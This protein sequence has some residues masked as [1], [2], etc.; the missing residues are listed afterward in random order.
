M[1]YRLEIILLFIFSE[2]VVSL[3]LCPYFGFAWRIRAGGEIVFLCVSHVASV[4]ATDSLI[5]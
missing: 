2:T 4:L 1:V 3:E 5:K